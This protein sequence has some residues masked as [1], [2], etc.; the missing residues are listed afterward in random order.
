MLYWL[1]KP[2]YIWELVHDRAGMT[3]QVVKKIHYSIN[4]AEH[5]ANPYSTTQK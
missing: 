3:N 1:A 2:T 4:D 5:F